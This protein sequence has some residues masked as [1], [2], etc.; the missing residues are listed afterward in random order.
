[1]RQSMTLRESLAIAVAIAVSL[2]LY[3]ATHG[4]PL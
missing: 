1:M 2:T 3:T 4:W